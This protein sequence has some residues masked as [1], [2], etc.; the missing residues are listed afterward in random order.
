[1]AL[2][3][4]QHTLMCPFCKMSGLLCLEG[5]DRYTPPPQ[6]SFLIC[7]SPVNITVKGYNKKLP[8]TSPS[9]MGEILYFIARTEIQGESENLF[10]QKFSQSHQQKSKKVLV[11][12][13]IFTVC[14][15]ARIHRFSPKPLWRI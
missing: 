11:N 9:I 8:K 6:C 2:D 4:I 5:C 7:R 10:S 3:S 15:S 1:M 14:Q 13:Q 12:F